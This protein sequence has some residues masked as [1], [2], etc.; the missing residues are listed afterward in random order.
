MP[1]SCKLG[2]VVT[3]VVMI[4]THTHMYVYVYIY[5]FI[6]IYQLLIYISISPNFKCFV[7]YFITF[8]MGLFSFD[9]FISFWFCSPVPLFCRLHH[10]FYRICILLGEVDWYFWLHF[11]FSKKNLAWNRNIHLSSSHTNV[12]YFIDSLMCFS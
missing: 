11:S 9:I 2:K 8:W 4:Q 5:N 6:V 3:E 7:D 1:N 12:L 10:A